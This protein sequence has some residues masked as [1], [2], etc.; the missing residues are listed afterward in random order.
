[1]L[2]HLKAELDGGVFEHEWSTRCSRMLFLIRRGYVPT[3]FVG[4]T[5]SLNS[6]TT[7]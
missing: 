6:D 4:N 5:S 2:F 3:G 7:L 1:M